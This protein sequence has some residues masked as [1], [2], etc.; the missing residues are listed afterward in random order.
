MLLYDGIMNSKINIIKIT[1]ILL[2]AHI[3]RCNTDIGNICGNYI[4]LFLHLA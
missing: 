3:Y 4:G 1:I 2:L